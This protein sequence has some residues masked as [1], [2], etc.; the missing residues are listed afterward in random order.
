MKQIYNIIVREIK[1]IF[2]SKLYIFALLLFPVTDCLFLGGIYISG[3]LTKLPIAVIDN[4]NTKIS[5]NI[6]RYFDAS[7]DMYVKYRLSNVQ[8]LQD[9]F[10]RQKVFLGVYIPKD[11]QKNIKKQKQQSITIFANSSNYITGNLTSID[12]ATIIASIGGGIKYKTLTKKGF[13][14]QQAKDLLQPVKNDT[15]K[16]FNPALNYNYYL[17]PGL[18]LSVIQQLLILFGT[19]TI[20]TEFD[21]KS[22]RSMLAV[23]RKSIFK[24]FLGKLIVYM[25]AAYLHFEILYRVL[26]PLF[27]IPM[28]HSITAAITLSLCF[29]FAAISLGL[30]LSSVLKTR[31][32]ALKGCLLISAP[33]FLLSGYT[34]PINQMPLLLQKL[35]QIIPLTPFLEGFR[36]I[37]Q[38]D[39]GL[40]YTVPFVKQLIIMGLIYFVLAYVL[41]N[42]R[43][44]KMEASG[45]IENMHI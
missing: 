16:L 14:S 37:Y 15:A 35:V 45:E 5:R 22:L 12:A 34:W 11:T 28:V 13:S 4:D 33:A 42:I 31:L 29:A 18:W 6:T 19:L 40:S 26:F 25:L 8:E 41:T 9:L 30:L 44:K 3:T 36:K 20:A 1:Y 10:S 21:L 17:T 39:I 2:T 27:K 24:V 38:Q 43:I 32:N 7:P 23:T